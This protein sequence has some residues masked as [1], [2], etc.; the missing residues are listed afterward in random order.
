VVEQVA[1]V[2][3]WLA[4]AAAVWLLW[5]PASSAFFTPAVFVRVPSATPRMPG[6]QPPRPV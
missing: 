1:A 5:R 6:Q 2:L 4:G 3:A